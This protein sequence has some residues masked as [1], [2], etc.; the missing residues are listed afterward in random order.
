M[1]KA[2][3]LLSGGLDSTLAGKLLQELGVEVE[4]VNFTS[5]F[6]RCTPRSLGCSAARR[7]A[8]QMGI[9]VKV[10]SAGAEYLEV[11]K[12]PKHGRGS[13]VN[14]CIDCR[15][16]MFRR[17]GEY[18][19]EIGADFVATG[20]VLGE[21]PMSQRREAMAII[22]RE[23][24]LAGQIVRPLSARLLPPSE[25]E[26]SGLV[27]RE[28]LLAFKGR[29]RGPQIELAGKLGLEDFL[30]PAGGCVLA[31]REF[32][33]RM[34]D[35]MEHCPDFGLR[36][37]RLLGLGRHF[38][39]PSGTKVIVGRD[40]SENESLAELRAGEELYL[41]PIELPGPGALLDAAASEADLTTAARLIATYTEGGSEVN[42]SVTGSEPG[43]GE[44]IMP[45]AQPLAEGLLAE[46]RI[47]AAPR[48]RRKRKREVTT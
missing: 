40:Q 38:R 11:I 45:K 6:C 29:S 18:A 33:A 15:I 22:E 24:G 28:K 46:W 26:K 31:D 2:L 48:S 1:P 14:P 35:L 30:C 21:R 19:K 42:V 43:T 36:E 39:L 16:F 3:L 34:R 44:R 37:A 32:A 27:D 10:F 4:A 47:G 7:A 5:P 17:A 41:D 8:Q 23:S 13:G 20:E 9:T 12:H 25:P